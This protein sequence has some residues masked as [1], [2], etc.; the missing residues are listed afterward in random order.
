M[1][2]LSISGR[3]KHYRA[4]R[5]SVL[6]AVMLIVLILF[7]LSL[8]LLLCWAFITTFKAQSEFRLNIIGLPKKWV[9]NYSTVIDMFYVMIMTDTGTEYVGIPEMAFNSLAYALGSSFAATAMPC[10]L[11]YLCA[12]FPYKYSKA[13]YLVAVVTMFISLVGTMPSQIQIMK[14]LGLYGHIWGLWIMSANFG[15]VNFMIFYG[16]S[17][18]ISMDYTNAAR[19][20]GAGNL[21]IF[22][23]I[24]FP[25]L[26][27]TFLTIMLIKFIGFWND[28]STPLVYAP[29]N[30]TLALGVFQM[31]TT[32][33]NQMSTV[34]MRLT[35]AMILLIPI[36]LIFVAFHNKIM[37][38]LNIGGIKG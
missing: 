33:I 16:M 36:L 1:K 4:D 6:T 18:G 28:Y 15:G 10:L 38:N 11:G 26:G 23:R 3:R 5:F 29:G 27:S 34:P 8:F 19:L 25:M 12:R 31:S 7:S 24:I 17:Q 14:T 13:I 20:D 21:T 22:L 35:A 2:T 30:P 9:W 37:E 32:N